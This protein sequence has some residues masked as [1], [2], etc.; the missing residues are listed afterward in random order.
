MN[1]KKKKPNPIYTLPE[2][3]LTLNLVFKSTLSKVKIRIKYLPVT[4]HLIHCSVTL[5]KH[6]SCIIKNRNT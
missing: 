1:K 4:L 2:S 3:L 5:K 6:I